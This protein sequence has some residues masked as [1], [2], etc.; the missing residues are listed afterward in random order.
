MQRF[1]REFVPLSD[2][3]CRALVVSLI[4]AQPDLAWQHPLGTFHEDWSYEAAPAARVRELTG[5]ESVGNGSRWDRRKTVISLDSL[6]SV[7]SCELRELLAALMT[8]H[9]RLAGELETVPQPTPDT[10]PANEVHTPA[11][12]VHR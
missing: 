10:L 3:V 8:H 5:G 1:I 4:T 2:D 11:L 7:T 9:L 6:Q 12:A